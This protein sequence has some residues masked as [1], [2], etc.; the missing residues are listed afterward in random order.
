VNIF[1]NITNRTM[2]P[3]NHAWNCLGDHAASQ[4]SPGFAE[5]T[6]CAARK[7]SCSPAAQIFLSATTASICVAAA[8]LFF[9]QATRMESNRNLAGWQEIASANDDLTQ[10]Q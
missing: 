4:L 9:T 1:V 7:A 2:N 10:G 6:L 3:E 8:V 5:R